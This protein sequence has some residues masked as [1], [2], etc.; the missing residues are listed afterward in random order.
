MTEPKRKKTGSTVKRK[1]DDVKKNDTHITPKT[2]ARK[3][4]ETGTGKKSSTGS[5]SG[6]RSSKKSTAGKT[7][8]KTSRS[9]TV[10]AKSA[11][12]IAREAEVRRLKLLIIAVSAV[13][14]ILGGL[15]IHHLL[16]PVDKGSLTG[17]SDEVLHYEDSVKKACKD[18]GISQFSTVM[19][20][21]MQQESSGLGTDVM[22]CSECPFNTEYDNTP[23]AIQDP[24]YSIQVGAEYFAY[25]LKEAGCKRIKNTER[26]KIALQDYNFGNSYA[27]WVL[28]NYGSYSIENATEFSLMMQEALGW[29]SYGDPEYVDHVL[30]YY[31]MP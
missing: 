27:T 8:R 23:N 13:I 5:V 6:T 26:L 22:Q 25:C 18:A 20:A 17:V 11:S 9:K 28:E 31:V 14:L 19:L 2:A 10:S 1:N 24:E 7:T 30:R 21:M 3:A 12:R 29:S 16:T 4:A 15:L